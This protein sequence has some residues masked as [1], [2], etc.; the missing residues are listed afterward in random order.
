MKQ[1]SEP[2][3]IISEHFKGVGTVTR[4][5]V[6]ERAREVALIN[7]RDPHHYSKEDYLEA[8]RELTGDF[9][10][11]G[12]QSD[13]VETMTNWDEDPEAAGHPV[14]RVEPADE[15]TLAEE[16]V[17]EGISEAEHEQLVEG[18]KAED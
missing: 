4:D 7:G 11:D 2:H 14:G 8:K 6:V 3:G 15:Q 5:M 13:P 16:L 10:V 1:R 9:S 17:E 12:E 18:A